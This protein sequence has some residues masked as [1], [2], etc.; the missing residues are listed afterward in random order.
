MIAIY[1]SDRRVDRQGLAFTLVELLVV[2]AIIGLL[3]ALLFPVLARARE[4]ARRTDCA[5][6]MRQI[7]VAFKM[8]AQDFDEYLPSQAP[9]E[10][11]GYAGVMSTWLMK[12]RPY[13]K[14]ADVTV[15]K[16]DTMTEPFQIPTTNTTV[17][18]SYACPWHMDGR[19]LAAIPAPTLTVLLGESVSVG[20]QPALTWFLQQLGKHSF[21]PDFG[22]IFE[23]PDFRHN[24]TGNYLFADTHLKALKGPNP[25]FIGYRKNSD[26]RALCG[27]EDPVPH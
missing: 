6:N 4:M 11:A 16:S 14:S 17:F 25:S 20:S 1:R 15:C 2:I 19:A 13:Y 23:H 21:T 5:S 3:A 10:V 27:R 8:Y 26:G 18:N 9:G 24:E 22:I 12:L 7:G